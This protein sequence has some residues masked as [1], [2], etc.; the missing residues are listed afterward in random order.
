MEGNTTFNLFKMLS[1]CVVSKAQLFCFSVPIPKGKEE[2]KTS[3]NVFVNTEPQFM[4]WCYYD[5]GTSQS[6]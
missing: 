6:K 4:S 5:L 1:N 3:Y 2:V